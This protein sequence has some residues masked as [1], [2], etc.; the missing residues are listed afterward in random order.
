MGERLGGEDAAWLHMDAATN[1]MVVTAWLEL[2]ARL[3]ASTAPA[4]LARIAALPRFR[5]RVVARPIGVP[6]WEVVL[7]FDPLPHFERVELPNDDALP[8]FIGGVVS[9]GLDRTRPLWRLYVVDRPGRGSGILCRVHHAVGDGFALIQSLLSLCEGL[10]PRAPRASAAPRALASI[11]SLVRLVTLPA[12]PTTSLGGSLGTEKRVA[13]SRPIPLADIKAAA[14]AASATVNDVLVS[15]FA[16]ALRR[17]LARRNERVD[18]LH[19]MVP[20]DLRGP[21]EAPSTGNRFGLVMLALPLDIADPAARIASVKERMGR[22]KGTPEAIVAYGLLSAMGWAPRWL[23][24]PAAS[25]FGNKASLVLTNVPGPRAPLSLEGIP[26]TGLTFWV[27]E[28]A[29]IGLGVSIL[30]YAGNVTMGVLSDVKVMPDPEALVADLHAEL[31][32]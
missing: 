17:Y 1:P 4:L 30:S 16:G 8:G 27:P 2:E 9:T 22:L 31:A 20:V 26:I 12:A 14:R 24:T 3:P 15:A 10:E 19:A 6:V 25:F 18:E 5:E 32:V 13:W 29:R 7:D 28:A 23:A 21:D 11:R